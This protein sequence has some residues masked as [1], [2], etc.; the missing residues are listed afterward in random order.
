M[1]CAP[2]LFIT[3]L[4]LLGL[5]PLVLNPALMGSKKQPPPGF[6][7]GRGWDSWQL[8]RLIPLRRESDKTHDNHAYY[9]YGKERKD[10]GVC[11]V[12]HCGITP[13]S[14]QPA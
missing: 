3:G 5:Y 14:S 12:H 8:V 6:R 1:I 7:A 13:A 10:E 9:H 4:H 2:V 11:V